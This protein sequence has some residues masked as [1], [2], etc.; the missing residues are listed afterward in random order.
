M[1]F[2][3]SPS[4]SLESVLDF[5]GSI[6][7]LFNFDIWKVI[8][9]PFTVFELFDLVLDIAKELVAFPGGLLNRVLLPLDEVESLSI[10]HFLAEY[11]LNLE[12]LFVLQIDHLTK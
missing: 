8:K 6:A 7:V 10:E 4:F 12:V 9:V 11:F 2:W 3:R 5:F 1:H